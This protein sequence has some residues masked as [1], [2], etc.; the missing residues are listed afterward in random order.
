[1]HDGAEVER[2][3]L[4]EGGR[5]REQRRLGVGSE[6]D[7]LRRAPLPPRRRQLDEAVAVHGQHGDPGHHVLEPAVGLEPADAPAELDRQGP[8]GEPR[9]LGDERAQQRHFLGGEVAPV[10]AAL[11]PGLLTRRFEALHLRVFGLIW[12]S[13]WWVGL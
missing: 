1:M 7:G 2:A 6:D 8:A 9:G 13:A 10:I 4:V 12:V 3:D 11:N 5:G